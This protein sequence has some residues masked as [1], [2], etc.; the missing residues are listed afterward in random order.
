MLDERLAGTPLVPSQPVAWMVPPPPPPPGNYVA[1][2]QPSF[3]VQDNANNVQFGANANVWP[4][5]AR[6]MANANVG[7]SGANVNMPQQNAR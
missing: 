1:I 7:Q 5:N 3:G 6:D 4:F 2:S